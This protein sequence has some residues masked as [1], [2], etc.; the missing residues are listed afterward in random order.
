[1]AILTQGPFD[2]GRLG[3]AR[4]QVLLK[5]V[6]AL[7]SPAREFK[8]LV[9]CGVQGVA[10]APVVRLEGCVHLLVPPQVSVR[11]GELIVA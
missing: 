3:L 4:A 11:P 7:I 5:Q 9:F 2:C 8:K 10:E 1:M 6:V